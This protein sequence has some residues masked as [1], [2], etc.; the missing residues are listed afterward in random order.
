MRAVL[1]PNVII[2]ALLSPSG[3]PARL[4][5]AWR[6]GAFELVASALLIAELERALAYPKI[7][8]LIPAGEAEEF[9]SW[10]VAGAELVDDPGEPPA[11]RSEDPGDDYLIALAAAERAALVSGDKHLQALSDRLPVFSPAQFSGMLAEPGSTPSS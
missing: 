11:I 1:D 6:D 2:S 5:R 10:M 9:I 4:L 8:R 7:Q 3:T